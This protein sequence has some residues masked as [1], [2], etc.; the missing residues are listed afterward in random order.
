MCCGQQ[1]TKDDFALP[2]LAPTLVD[3]AKEV[4]LGRGFQLLKYTL[5]KLSSITRL[6][7]NRALAPVRYS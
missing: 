5:L 7:F 4:T 6:V 3:L 2:N 1:L